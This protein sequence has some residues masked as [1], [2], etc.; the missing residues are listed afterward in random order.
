[1]TKYNNN[2]KTRSRI[3]L[4]LEN[5]FEW[6]ENGALIKYLQIESKTRFY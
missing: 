2:N 3:S 1:M 5:K 4:R 6:D